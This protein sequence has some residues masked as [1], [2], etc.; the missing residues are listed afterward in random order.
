MFGFTV[1]SSYTQ[2]ANNPGAIPYPVKGDRRVGGHAIV[3]CGYD[4]AKVI[5]NS[6]HGA[7]PTK[8]ALLIRNSWGTTWGE[9]GTAGSHIS[10]CWTAWPPTGGA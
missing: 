2:A 8:G 4:D 9:D 7:D 1:F 6:A 10:T 3:A 5:T